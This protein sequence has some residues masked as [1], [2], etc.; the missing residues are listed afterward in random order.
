MRLFK[1]SADDIFKERAEKETDDIWDKVFKEE[2]K[3]MTSQFAKEIS[4]LK[5]SKI[6]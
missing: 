5:T 4:T 3:E 2:Y 6:E 1:E